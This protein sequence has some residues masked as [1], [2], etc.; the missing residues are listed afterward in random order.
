MKKK[1][2]IKD[3]VDLKGKRQLTEVHPKSEEECRACEAAGIDMLIV[4]EDVEMVRRGAPNT[5]LTVGAMTP[6][7]ACSDAGAIRVG[8]DRMQRGADA[9]YTGQSIERV[10]AMARE[11]LP[12]VGHVGLVPYRSSWYGGMRAVGKTAPEALN[13]YRE[14]LA[15][16]D[17]GAIAVE[18]EVVPEK[19]AAEIS[20]RVDITVISLGSGL[21]CDAQ[22]LFACDILNITDGHIPRHAKTYTDLQPELARI[23]EMRVNAFRAFHEDVTGNHF[24]EP[25]HSI[26][27][28]DREFDTFMSEID[29]I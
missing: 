22:Y 10:R 24:P 19:I 12:V 1:L 11:K 23:Q 29:K 27:I 3:I 18:M 13:I 7:V 9:V 21:G 2:T 17:A 26:K 8:I 14:V 25:K 4:E 28:E 16:Q 6:E 20:R 15:Y 5:F